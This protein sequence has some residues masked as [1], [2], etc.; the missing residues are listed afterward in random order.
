M[1]VG[2]LVLASGDEAKSACSSDDKEC[3]RVVT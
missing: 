1:R 3:H 2:I